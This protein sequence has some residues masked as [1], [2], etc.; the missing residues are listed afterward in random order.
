MHSLMSLAKSALLC[1]VFILAEAHAANFKYA[2]VQKASR[3]GPTQDRVCVRDEHNFP[4][5]G[6]FDG[7]GGTKAASLAQAKLCKYLYKSCAENT[8]IADCCDDN[9]R[10]AF[11]KVAQETLYPKDDSGS[12]A[13]TVFFSAVDGQRVLH[14]AHIGDSTAILKNGDDLQILTTYH[15]PTNPEEI[16]RIKKAKGIKRK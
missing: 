10:K 8:E 4:C 7:N 14:V 11:E 12:T 2:W 3:N 6:L 13:L 9:I 15:R 1:G 5:F 16:I